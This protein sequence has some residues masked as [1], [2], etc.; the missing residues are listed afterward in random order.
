MS[1][2]NTTKVDL[3]IEEFAEMAGAQIESA[4]AKARATS[5]KYSA[6][7]L[8][9]SVNDSQE[10]MVSLAAE[11]VA[12]KDHYGNSLS[13]VGTNDKVEGFS[14][15][16][17]SADT[18]QWPLWLALY[19]DSWV[20]KRAIDKPAQ[21]MISAGFTLRGQ[22]NYEVVYKA[23]NRYK[24][25]LQDLLKWGALFGGAIAVILFENVKNEDFKK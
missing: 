6:P 12:M 11:S 9:D 21:D 5:N 8:F 3:S 16:G 13:S 15:Y 24:V 14:T 1:E 17:F 25:Q 10:K 2:N 23:Y 18:L 19:N 7:S 4:L 22:K 20:F